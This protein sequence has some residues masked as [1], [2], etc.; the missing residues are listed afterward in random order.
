MQIKSI[1]GALVM[2]ATIFTWYA[3]PA[4]GASWL[5][6][7]HHRGTG[8]RFY[9]DTQ[10]VRRQ[11]PFVFARWYDNKGVTPKKTGRKEWL[12]YTA[13][14]DCALRTIQSMKVERVD[15]RSGRHIA[16][17]DLRGASNSRPSGIRPGSNMAEKL[18]RRVC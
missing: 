16:T 14:I 12:V 10:S 17:I 3:L 18:R 9:Y 2:G 11:G 5:E 1:V 8:I 7:Y 4:Y 13:R 6:Y 15:A